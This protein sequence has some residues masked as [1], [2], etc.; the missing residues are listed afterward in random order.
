[1]KLLDILSAVVVVDF[2][3]IGLSKFFNLGKSL[4]KWYAKFGMTAVLSDCLIIVLG[5]QLALLIEPKAGWFHLLMI[6]LAIQIFHDIW[7]YFAVV[8]PIPKGHNQIIDLFKEYADENSWKI[9]VADS[10][11]VGST[12][13]L[14]ELLSY[15]HES[16]VSFVGLLATYALTYIIYTR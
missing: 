9:I 12:V 14:A 4:D 10:L 7:F 3:T 13:I 6:A 8:V 1:M 2:V 5:I 11:M 15:Y 16:V